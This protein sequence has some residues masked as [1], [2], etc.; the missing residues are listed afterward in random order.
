[1]V[2]MD[3]YCID[4]GTI[5]LEQVT[6]G[7]FSALFSNWTTIK[8]RLLYY[9]QTHCTM[10]CFDAASTVFLVGFTPVMTK[11]PQPNNNWTCGIQIQS[12][13]SNRLILS[14]YPPCINAA[15]I[16]LHSGLTASQRLYSN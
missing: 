16:R 11:S 7:S 8:K 4:I 9:N 2:P 3:V 6:L 14:W 10:L 12:S 13:A 1:M 5:D 15:Y